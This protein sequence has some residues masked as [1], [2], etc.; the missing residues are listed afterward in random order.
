MGTKKMYLDWAK[1]KEIQK[2]ILTKGVECL[3]L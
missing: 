1:E 3:I 2:L